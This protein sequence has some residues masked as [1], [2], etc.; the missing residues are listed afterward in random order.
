MA[1]PTYMWGGSYG[2]ARRGCS[3]ADRRNRYRGGQTPQYTGA[4]QPDPDTGR[5]IFGNTA[6]TYMMA[7]VASPADDATTTP[8]TDAFAIVVPR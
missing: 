1:T 6:P 7:P 4:G 3:A 2:E 8:Q 5:S